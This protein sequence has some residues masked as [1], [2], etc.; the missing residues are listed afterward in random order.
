MSLYR[1]GLVIVVSCLHVLVFFHLAQTGVSRHI[2]KS[3]DIS[4]QLLPLTANQ[5]IPS[6]TKKMAVA[7]PRPILSPTTSLPATSTTT[8]TERRPKEV[9]S[10]TVSEDQSSIAPVQNVPSSTAP[11]AASSA[12]QEPHNAAYLNNPKPEYPAVSRRLQEAGKVLL[13]V[14][15]DAS[16][17]ATQVEVRN[18]SGF[19]RL[20]SAAV[21]AVW[22]WRFIPAKRGETTVAAWVLIPLN[23]ELNS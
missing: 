17:M 7:R 12:Y 6:P 1:I 2:E 20:D 3:M 13:R 16:G 22:Q 18:S 14:H 19:S 4:V 5:S 8:L 10:P 11:N 23:F 21:K 15:V 9:D